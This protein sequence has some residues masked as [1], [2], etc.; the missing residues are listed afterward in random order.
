MAASPTTNTEELAPLP[1]LCRGNA[2]ML[3]P[4]SLF[5]SVDLKLSLIPK[6]L[7]FWRNFLR[8]QTQHTSSLFLVSSTATRVENFE[9]LSVWSLS[10]ACLH[11]CDKGQTGSHHLTVWAVDA[12][13]Y[14]I[15]KSA[16]KTHCQL[17]FCVPGLNSHYVTAWVYNTHCLR[18]SLM[19]VSLIAFSSFPFFKFIFYFVKLWSVALLH[20]FCLCKASLSVKNAY[21]KNATHSHWT[22]YSFTTNSQQCW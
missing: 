10:E 21:K 11:N 3:L 2:T 16:F 7:N 14:P 18:S 4:S 15:T 1:P 9:S 12:G 6:V 13:M 8:P 17:M 20:L 5:A 22:N 19:P